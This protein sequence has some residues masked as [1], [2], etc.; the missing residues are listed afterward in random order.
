MT[1]RLRLMIYYSGLLILILA[2]FGTAVFMMLNW[3]LQAQVDNTLSRV[4]ADVLQETGGALEVTEA[5]QPRLTAYVPR[6][7]TFRTPGVYVQIWEVYD[8]DPSLFSTS[9]NLGAFTQPLDRRAL[10]A[11]QEVR[12]EVT[13]NGTH[14]RVITHPITIQ[15]QQVGNVQAAASL[16]VVEAATDRLMKIMLGGGVIALLLS[17]LIG[18]Y[19][20]RRTLRPIEAIVSTAQ[21]ITAADDLGRRI[22]DGDVQDELGR[23]IRVFNQT[24]ARLERSFHA[25]P[26]F[27]A[28]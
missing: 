1:L 5:G 25:Q 14:L 4:L 15:G 12:S 8:G 2:L 16:T 19:L 21:S 23:M 6:L 27:R 11:A 13:I 18:D 10:G 9:E 24:L 3:T 7:D 26:L 17:L 20:A 22:P 28:I